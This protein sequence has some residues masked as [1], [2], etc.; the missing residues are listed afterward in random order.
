MLEGN[1]VIFRYKKI[2]KI[3]KFDSL[4]LFSLHVTCDNYF[5]P[6][7]VTDILKCSSPET[8]HGMAVVNFNGFSVAVYCILVIYQKK[9]SM[10]HLTL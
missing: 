2:C 4:Y 8:G 10:P 7:R 1:Q 6:R 5:L 9:L 3:Q